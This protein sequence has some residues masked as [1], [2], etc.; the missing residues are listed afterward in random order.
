MLAWIRWGPWLLS[1]TFTSLLLAETREPWPRAL[2]L[3][4]PQDAAGLVVPDLKQADTETLDS[5][6]EEGAPLEEAEES[7]TT[8]KV[9]SLNGAGFLHKGRRKASSL[10][11]E[12][13]PMPVRTRIYTGG[14]GLV[15]LGAAERYYGLMLPPTSLHARLGETDKN[16]RWT[17]L[18][19]KAHLRLTCKGDAPHIRWKDTSDDVWRGL[20]L[21][22]DSESDLLIIRDGA[23]LEIYQ[24]T[25][26]SRFYLP[27][28]ALRPGRQEGY[29]RT[30]QDLQLSA[31]KDGRTRVDLFPQ[32]LLRLELK[33][34]S[35]HLTIGSADPDIW[36]ERLLQ[37]SPQLA[38]EVAKNE[39]PVSGAIRALRLRVL[40]ERTQNLKNDEASL[41]ELIGFSR[42]EEALH[43]LRRL[44][45]EERSSLG[46][47]IKG[48]EAFL[49][50]RLQQNE[51]AE[52]ESAALSSSHPMRGV[53]REEKWLAQLRSQN[54]ST[55]EWIVPN[56][57]LS[58]PILNV[59]ERYLLGVSWQRGEQRRAALDFWTLGAIDQ[60]P[61]NLQKSR[62]EWVDH[63][64]EEKRWFWNLGLSYGRDSNVPEDHNGASVAPT[65]SARIAAQGAIERVL[66]PS[67]MHRVSLKL[68]IEH[69]LFQEAAY[70][71]FGLSRVEVSLPI[72]LQ[73][74]EAHDYRVTLRPFIGRKQ[75]GSSANIDFFAYDLQLSLPL[76]SGRFA[77]SMRQLQGLDP[78]PAGEAP[79]DLETGEKGLASDQGIRTLSLESLWQADGSRRWR[80]R[81]GFKFASLNYRSPLRDGY[82]RQIF[83]LSAGVTHPWNLAWSSDVKA[84]AGFHQFTTPGSRLSKGQIASDLQIDTIFRTQLRWEHYFRFDV[85]RR[86]SALLG[87]P[88]SSSVW[89]LGSRYSW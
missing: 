82:D 32:Q 12:P 74:D 64:L 60:E 77:Q 9:W 49:L 14:A 62:E 69:E 89:E 20:S 13:I 41:R 7:E 47:G 51:L 11:A 1:L 30:L 73:F 39:T 84:S 8:I 6:E 35:F 44:S 4:G 65:A 38:S 24:L 79:L 40:D 71:E 67:Q 43:I 78:D 50:F 56:L 31:K 87:A 42:Y 34:G 18:E 85:G 23:T 27:S 57:S 22:P 54:L 68:A 66:D 5:F 10:T 37:S 81:Y 52:K 72:E 46:D 3:F 15:A 70:K 19:D 2:E 36:G 76:A 33:E 16:W 63:L 86:P 17:L 59:R 45:D 26:R 80:Q 48:L 61:M 88:E 29:L 83:E 25:G 58:A 75:R 55:S 21:L 53:L 28:L